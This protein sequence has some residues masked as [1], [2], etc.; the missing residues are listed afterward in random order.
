MVRHRLFS[1]SKIQLASFVA[2]QGV[3]WS[4]TVIGFVNGKQNAPR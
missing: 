1:F 2:S 4:N 3:E